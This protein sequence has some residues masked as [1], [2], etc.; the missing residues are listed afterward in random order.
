MIAI[1]HS[2]YSQSVHAPA[3][4]AGLMDNDAERY[5]TSSFPIFYKL[6]SD[7]AIYNI[8]VHSAH[9]HLILCG[10]FQAYLMFVTF[11]GG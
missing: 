3:L 10:Q 2:I 5:C 1:V 6:S 7:I 8:T 9:C 4:N 11:A